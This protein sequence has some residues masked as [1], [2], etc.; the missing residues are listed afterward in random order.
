MDDHLAG[1]PTVD[2]RSRSGGTEE[3]DFEQ[4]NL[5]VGD[6]KEWNGRIVPY[7]QSG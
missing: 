3:D 7:F 1:K 2:G 6:G 4:E 5:I